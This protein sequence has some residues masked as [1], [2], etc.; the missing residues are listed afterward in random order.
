M[1]ATSDKQRN[2]CNPITDRLSHHKISIKHH[3]RINIPSCFVFNIWAQNLCLSPLEPVSKA[4]E[5][6]FGTQ[7]AI[8]DHK[9][10]L[11]SELLNVCLKC[12]S[13]FFFLELFDLM[14]NKREKNAAQVLHHQDV[15]TVDFIWLR[16]W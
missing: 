7:K 11:F 8:S 5:P 3:E 9:I 2:T 13:F 4:A 6:W 14:I 15:K 10:D 1:Q 12:F 16:W